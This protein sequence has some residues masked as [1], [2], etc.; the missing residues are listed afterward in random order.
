MGYRAS[1]ARHLGMEILSLSPKKALLPRY[2]SLA[3]INNVSAAG[4]T[5]RGV[6]RAL[7]STN[8]HGFC[9]LPR[10]SS[11]A[12]PM[13]STPPSLSSTRI[14]REFALLLAG[15]TLIASVSIHDAMLI[16]VH[17]ESI[18]ADERNPVGRWL[19]EI[20]GGDIWL[21]VLVKLLGTSAAC[22]LL[23]RLF[24]VRPQM[25]LIAAGAVTCFQLGLLGYLSLG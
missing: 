18:L 8:A 15:C 23:I 16:V 13:C 4:S 5:L 2:G 21:F 7:P 24:E 1:I 11:V 14:S 25:A 17:H 12:K 10:R 19:L 9:V 3:A 20:Q 22:A 6:I